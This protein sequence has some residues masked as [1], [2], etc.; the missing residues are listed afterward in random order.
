MSI[1]INKAKE[2]WIVDRFR[3]EFYSH[4]KLETSKSIFQ[5]ETVWIMAPWTWKKL[6]QKQLSKKNV[7]CTIHHIDF[8]KFKDE[9]YLN[10]KELESYVDRF[11]TISKISYEDLSKL[12]KKDISI[13]PFWINQNNFY[14]ID[15]K[16]K[17]K[18]KFGLPKDKYLIGSFQ[19]DTEGKDLKSPKLIKGPDIFIEYILKLKD[20]IPN[21]HVVLTGKRRQYV[22]SELKSH[23]ITYSY[24]EMASIKDLNELYNI[25]N[26]YIVSSRVEGG[27]QAILECAATKTPIISNN[28]GVAKTILSSESIISKG[29]VISAIPNVE[30]AFEKVQKYMLPQ[31]IDSFEKLFSK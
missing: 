22:I 11:H 6:N 3:K 29:D 7:I 4:T 20:R 19:R 2:N 10:F 8:E 26:L 30:H 27:P 31:G 23:N 24:F 12:T 21:L 1:Y 13:I 5:S 9:D 16:E 15:N 14:K 17:I 18:N 28:V 25:L